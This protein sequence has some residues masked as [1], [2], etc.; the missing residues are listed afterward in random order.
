M[1][2]KIKARILVTFFSLFLPLAYSYAEDD[3]M[4]DFDSIF[5]DAEDTEETEAEKA[6]TLQDT[7][8]QGWNIP[9]RFTGS[10]SAQ[11]VASQALNY[12]SD[13]N[14]YPGAY[15]DTVLGTIFTPSEYLTVYS[16]VIAKLPYCSLD[17]NTFYIDYNLLDHAFFTVG[18][19]TRSWGNSSI[20]DTDILDDVTGDPDILALLTVPLLKGSNLEAIV[21]LDKSA[22]S[23]SNLDYA[24]SLEFT[25]ASFSIKPFARTW[26]QCHGDTLD[27]PEAGDGAAGLYVT[28]D[29]K[30]WH[31]TFYG[32]AHTAHNSWLTYN[33]SKFVAGIGRYWEIPQKIG[34]L[35]E[36]EG[37]VYPNED[38]KYNQSIGLTAAWSHMCGS[39]FTP[40]FTGTYD[41]T[42][43]TGVFTPALTIA[44]VF[45]HAS[46]YLALPL[47][48]GNTEEDYSNDDDYSYILSGSGSKQLKAYGTIY[49]KMS[50]SF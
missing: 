42:D 7:Q 39:R 34:F 41:I 49:L 24:M 11:L 25:I 27:D 8:Q 10:F 37:L 16:S 46:I 18:K 22:F 15:A 44:D 5:D 21:R 48:Y 13:K 50:A 32:D 12:W 45:P 31:L 29:I 20:F 9:L 23:A 38:I 26:A 3:S 33:Y 43:N 4:E 47:I 40:A 36:Y 30:D 2:K 14:F 6:P 35:M 19:T 17:L 1:K 28:G